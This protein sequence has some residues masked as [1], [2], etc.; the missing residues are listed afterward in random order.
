MQI[1]QVESGG[2]AASGARGAAR[3]GPVNLTRALI[4]RKGHYG[5][6]IPGETERLTGVRPLRESGANPMRRDSTQRYVGPER[7]HG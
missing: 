1:L 2:I 7:A 5:S 6:G 3:I 4:P